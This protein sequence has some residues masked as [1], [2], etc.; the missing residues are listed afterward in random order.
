MPVIE[1]GGAPA[2]ASTDPPLEPLKALFNILPP[3]RYLPGVR[4]VLAVPIY[5]NP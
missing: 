2:V 3:R 4:L 5:C 1:M